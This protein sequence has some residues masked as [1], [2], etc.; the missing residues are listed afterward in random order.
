MEEDSA[1]RRRESLKE[2]L[3]RVISAHRLQQL[4][5]SG[6]LCFSSLCFNLVKHSYLA[7]A[8]ETDEFK[9]EADDAA[10]VAYVKQALQPENE[11]LFKANKFIPDDLSEAIDWLQGKT[12]EEIM[13]AREGTIQVIEDLGKTLREQGKVQKWFQDSACR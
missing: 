1:K 12:A 7:G 6:E 3:T 8:T 2:A 4:A 13:R 9:H 5:E 11:K 10:K